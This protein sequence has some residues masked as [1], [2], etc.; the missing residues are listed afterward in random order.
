MSGRHRPGGK[1]RRRTARAPLLIAG[2]AVVATGTTLALHNL[3]DAGGCSM[4]D[5]IQLQVAADPAIAPPLR[6]VAGEWMDITEPEVNGRCVAIEVTEAATADVAS[7]LAAHIGGFMDVAAVDAPA[8]TPEASD[9]PAVWV[10]DSTYW[11]TRM[12]SI[13]RAAFEGEAPSLASSPIVLAVSATGVEVFGEGPIP[14]EAMREPLLAGLLAAQQ[15]ETPPLALGLPEPRRD[16][17]GLV[18]A[19]WMQSAVV[20][21][22][23][24]LFQIVGLFRGLGDAPSDTA[25]LLPK[26]QQGVEAAPVSE[27]AVISHNASGTADPIRAVR[28][29]DAPTLDFP[30]AVLAGQPGDVRT[31]ASM[32]R[33]AVFNQPEVFTRYGFRA[34]DGT[35]GSGFP[36]GHGVTAEA[37]PS[38]PVGPPER[39]H[40]ARRIWTSATSEARV[41]SVVNINASMGLPF[42]A[43]APVPR[44]AVFQQTALQG[45]E[46]FTP[47]TDLGHWE[48]AARLDGDRDWVE[49]VPIQLL[50]DEHKLRI[51][52]ALQT[53]QPVAQNE[54]A[55][56]ETLL[57]AYEEMKDGWDETRSN[58]L[59]MWTDSGST[60]QDGLTLDETLRELERLTDITRPI[61][62]I[63]LGL[64]PDADME[65]LEALAHATGGA[66]FPV[67]DPAE[68]NLIFLRALLALP[69]A[70]ET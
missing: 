20:T 61:R 4:A 68:I 53:I 46:M 50:D 32:F 38:L 27:Q 51:Q 18:G 2:V 17:A 15:G 58:T 67:N 23:D 47:G 36:I 12:Q 3:A 56:F 45:M 30:F 22:D 64:G 42:S 19:A 25:A 52:Q 10:P 65:Q 44:L 62:V 31:A 14:A 21:T 34:P 43:E 6:Q 11:I 13:S 33:N 60:K 57:A 63:L 28:V 5:G 24:E 59:V 1:L 54:S 9:I 66:A 41:L 55:M 40:Q 70:S 48:Y 7:T 37:V 35:A 16:T 69:P 29:Q 49:G 26:F 8:P 39:F